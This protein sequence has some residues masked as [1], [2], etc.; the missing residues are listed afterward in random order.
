MRLLNS[1]AGTIFSGVRQRKGKKKDYS[2]YRGEIQGQLESTGSA[3]M[4]SARPIRRPL[5]TPSK[6]VTND[7]RSGTLVSGSSQA[8]PHGAADAR[9]GRTNPRE[10]KV[11]ICTR[12]LCSWEVTYTSPAHLTFIYIYLCRFILRVAHTVPTRYNTNNIIQSHKLQQGFHQAAQ[13]H[14]FPSVG[15]QQQHCHCFN[16]IFFIPVPESFFF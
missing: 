9:G 1:H 16:R 14:I 13:V 3:Q 6:W 15:K 12:Q 11:V 7:R 5:L 10:C 4:A 8:V 2:D